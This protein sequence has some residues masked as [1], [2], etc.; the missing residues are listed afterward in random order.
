MSDYGAGVISHPNEYS[1]S[2]YHEIRKPKEKYR[3]IDHEQLL[4]LSNKC[5]MA[6][7]IEKIDNERYSRVVEDVLAK[8]R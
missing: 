2:G 3:L 8:C 1:F 4:K 5:S 7:L 6:Y